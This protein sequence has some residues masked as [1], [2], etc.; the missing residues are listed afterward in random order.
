MRI[1]SGTVQSTPVNW[2]PTLSNIAPPECR[3]RRALQKIWLTV[4]NNNELPIMEHVRDPAPAWLR[5]RKAPWRQAAQYQILGY[6]LQ[7]EWSNNYRP[8][9]SV[10]PVT[11]HT[12]QQPGFHL[13]RR[14]W[15]ALN[16]LRTGHGCCGDMLHKWGMRDDPQCDCGHPKQTMQHILRDCPIRAYPGTIDSAASLSPEFLQ[17]LEAL[18][19]RL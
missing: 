11:N 6:D 7:D 3:R 16:R 12:S 14:Q 18:D 19:V 1:I 10:I 13:P 5:S 4:A 9:H 15:T 2:L 8:E 17:W